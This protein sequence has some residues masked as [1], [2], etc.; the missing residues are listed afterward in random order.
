MGSY[1]EQCVQAKAVRAGIIEQRSVGTK[2][3]QTKSVVVECRYTGTMK[4]ERGWRKWRS[5]A[6]DETAQQAASQLNRKYTVTEF[7]VRP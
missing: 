5:Y 2:K 1:R 4:G 6:D 3:R 7:R